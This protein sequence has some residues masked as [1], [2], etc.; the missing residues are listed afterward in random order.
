MHLVHQY[1]PDYVGGTELY[2]QTLATMQAEAGHH[3]AVF[4][5]SPR[6]EKGRAMMADREAGVRVYR[7]L[8]GERTRTQVFRDSFGQR[9]LL[10]ALQM[11]LDQEAPDLVHVQHLMGMPTGLVDLLVD[12]GIPYVVTLHDYW[13]FCANAQLLTNTD[14]TICAGP[15]DR[16]VN[17]GQCALVRAGKRNIGWVAPAVAPVMQMRNK[18]LRGILDRASH[19]VA[20]TEFVR[21]TY[22]AA[23]MSS[24]NMVTILHGIEMPEKEL[25]TARRRLAT[26]QRDGCLRIGYV[27]SIGWQKGVHILIEAVNMLPTERVYL[28]LYGDLSSFPDY[29][30]Q[31][32]ELVQHPGITL[33]GPVSREDLWMALA[34]FDVVILPTLWYETSSLILDEVFAMGIPVVA[35]RI[36]VMA[37]KVRDGVNGR[38]FAAGDAVALHRVLLDLLE[39]PDLLDDWR[40]GIPPV[41]TIHEHVGEIERLYQ[42]TWHAV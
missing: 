18:R 7:L 16:A 5:P 30:T 20:P 28:T 37:E 27:G 26:R 42:S 15:D 10:G 35:S 21:Q 12:A 29:V 32:Q 3:V 17:C 2:T 38:L 4:C 40:S 33:A 14:Q 24:D 6:S 31:L 19:V 36:G 39:N 9:Q 1:P 41:R 34:E 25:E 13:Y 11:I 23:G 8:V 22:A